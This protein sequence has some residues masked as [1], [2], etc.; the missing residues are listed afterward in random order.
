[1]L[2]ALMGF[3][4]A[5]LCVCAAYGVCHQIR[6]RLWGDLGRTWWFY[7]GVLATA[8]LLLSLA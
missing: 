2:I 6:H 7:L 1:M 3:A 4:V 5:L 8:V